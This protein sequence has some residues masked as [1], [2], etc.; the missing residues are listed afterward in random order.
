MY[1]TDSFSTLSSEEEDEVARKKAMDDAWTPPQWTQ[2]LVVKPDEKHLQY[3]SK[4]WG[5]LTVLGLGLPPVIPYMGKFNWLI[6][7]AQL[8]YRGMPMEE[9]ER[10]GM[11]LNFGGYSGNSGK[12]HRKVAFALGFGIWAV[13]SLVLY[14]AMPTWVRGERWEPLLMYTLQNIFFFLA[15]C[16]LQPYK[17]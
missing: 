17:G 1:N 12:G 14:A 6:C 8:I 15:S 9:R 16:Y 3:Q 2:G 10:G 5:G 13:G 11:G 7:V 4:L